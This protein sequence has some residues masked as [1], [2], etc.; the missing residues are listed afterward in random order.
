MKGQII[1]IVSD[2]HI[3]SANGKKYDCKCRGKFRKMKILP[4]V[5]DYVLFDDDQCN[6][7]L[8]NL[9]NKTYKKFTLP[10]KYRDDTQMYLAGKEKKML[11]QN[12]KEV[13]LID[14]SDM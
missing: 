5:G 10:K 3:V 13:Y 11:V 1:K 7:Y 14:I 4:L 6:D 2:L 9:R 8:C 12:G